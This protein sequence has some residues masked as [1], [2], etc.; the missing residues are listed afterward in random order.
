MGRWWRGSDEEEDEGFDPMNRA[1]RYGTARQRGRVSR[2]RPGR[3]GVGAP[4]RVVWLGQTP[5]SDPTAC[6]FRED[7]ESLGHRSTMPAHGLFSFHRLL[8]KFL[9][10]ILSV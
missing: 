10:I 4:S 8:W 5:G 6:W 9:E 3:R 7:D 2:S 1:A